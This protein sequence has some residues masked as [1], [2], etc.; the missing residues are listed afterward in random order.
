MLLAL[1]F[2]FLF[3]NISMD[4]QGGFACTKK[5][6][7]LDWDAF[8]TVFAMALLKLPVHRT[9]SPFPLYSNVNMCLINIFPY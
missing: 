4:I 6:L 2:A 3:W 8:G 5:E 1:T 9:G 7:S